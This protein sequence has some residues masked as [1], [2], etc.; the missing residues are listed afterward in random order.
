MIRIL[1][2]GFSKRLFTSQPVWSKKVPV[3]PLTFSILA[4]NFITKTTSTSKQSTFDIPICHLGSWAELH[5]RLHV[6][7]RRKT[8][9][10]LGP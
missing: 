4:A 7:T 8:A 2:L 9:K 6:P 5:G 3:E 1:E 10:A